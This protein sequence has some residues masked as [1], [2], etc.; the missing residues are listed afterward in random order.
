MVDEHV[1][2][3]NSF[4]A[5]CISVCS[6]LHAGAYP[7]LFGSTKPFSKLS[8]TFWSSCWPLRV[9]YWGI[10]FFLGI[11]GPFTSFIIFWP[12]CRSLWGII[13]EHIPFGQ[14]CLHRYLSYH[15]ALGHLTRSSIF[16]SRQ[17]SLSLDFWG[18]TYINQSSSCQ[19]VFSS[20]WDRTY[21]DRSC[22]LS[23]WVWVFGTAPIL[24]GHHL[25]SLSL[26]FRRLTYIDQPY[27]Y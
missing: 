6:P 10:P 16:L 15:L 22:N 24:I 9:A 18:C 1:S 4:E 21:I 8:F 25:V 7:S 19:F 17:F 27:S 26:I 13:L 11:I 23:V 5:F 2:E 12:S 20:S 3:H 14:V